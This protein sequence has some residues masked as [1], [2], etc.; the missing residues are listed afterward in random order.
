M[1]HVK[2]C[3][4]IQVSLSDYWFSI[5]SVL[6]SSAWIVSRETFLQRRL[7]LAT[8]ILKPNRQTGFAH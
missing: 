1:F 7:L 4:G 5:A 6:T 2:Q 3:H 8:P